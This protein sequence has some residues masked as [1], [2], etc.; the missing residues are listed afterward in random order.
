MKIV[1]LGSGSLGS[2]IGGTLAAGGSEVYLIDQ[3][4]EHINT[5]RENGLKLRET[6]VE[7]TVRVE[8]RTNCAG[9]G[10]ADLVIV[11]VK[12]FHTKE[13]VA[14]AREVIGDE[15]AVMSLQN[16]LGN[17]EVI[18]GV[19]GA[20]KVVAGRTYVGSVL[21]APGV[22][23]AGT[24][25][26]MTFIG[27]LG[28]RMTPR[29]ERIAAAFRDA[30]LD[31]EISENI[32][33]LIWDKLLV[34]VATGALS[35][36]TRL[37]YGGLYSLEELKSCALAAVREGIALA[38]ALN[39]ALSEYD[40]EKI[41]YKASE[42]LSP[43]FKTSMLQSVE[44]GAPTEIDFVNGA[45]VRLAERIGGSAPVNATLAACVKGI[46][47]YNGEYLGGKKL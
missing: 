35:A 1:M 41:W 46:E 21:L 25:G 23:E 28:G 38:G 19:I 5:I 6:G 27:E 7:K 29:I 20:E 18:G 40:S 32:T 2:A 16:G 31:T 10:R 12:S 33:G 22:V 44:K 24:R 43:A 13:A 45:L 30:G 42:G 39:I 26:K 36:I 11:L 47:L 37:P 17:E 8:A 14:Q 3:W 34:N 4:E 9:I 15:T